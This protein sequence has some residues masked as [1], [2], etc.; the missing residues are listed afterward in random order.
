M[1]PKYNL[2]KLLSFDA[3]KQSLHCIV[4]K[5]WQHNWIF[6]VRK[7]QNYWFQ[8]VGENSDLKEITFAQ[9]INCHLTSNYEKLHP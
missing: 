6:E 7:L 9:G 5:L 8:D 4:K 1:R 3:N 2:K